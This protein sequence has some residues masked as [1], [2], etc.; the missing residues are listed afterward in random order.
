MQEYAT[1]MAIESLNNL[2]K[3]NQL[4]RSA[5]VTIEKL[6]DKI[7]E[8]VDIKMWKRITDIERPNANNYQDRIIIKAHK[9]AEAAK[10]TVKVVM[11]AEQFGTF[12]VKSFKENLYYNVALRQV[13]ESNCR[14]LYCR[15]C[16][17]CIHRYRCDCPEYMVE[18]YYPFQ[19][20]G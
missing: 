13:C 2:L 6:L 5:R 18:K 15:V 9:K 19:R 12:L 8:L 1:N 4:K 10:N 3:T 17:I 7:E 16:K 20:M 14:T 11:D